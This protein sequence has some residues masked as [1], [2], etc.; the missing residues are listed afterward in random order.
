M[1]VLERLLT[2]PVLAGVSRPDLVRLLETAEVRTVADEA[3]LM[4]IGDL[5]EDIVLVIDGGFAVELGSGTST[6]PLAFV[7]AGEILGETALFRRSSS[8]SARVRAV[9]DSVI[10]RL[11]ST[12]LDQ[13]SR[14]GSGL[15]RFIEEAVMRTMARRVHDSILAIDGV[16]SSAIDPAEPKGALRRLREMFRR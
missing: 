2:L 15:P 8:R 11:D 6:L 16:L 7:G 13:L 14:E 9:Q 3:L 5:G 1:D 10:I 12:L 4:D